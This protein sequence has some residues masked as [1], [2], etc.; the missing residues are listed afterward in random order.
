[1]QQISAGRGLHW[2]DLLNKL[3]AASQFPARMWRGFFASC[4]RDTGNA[5]SD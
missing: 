4:S 1:M 5:Y 3:G 2:V